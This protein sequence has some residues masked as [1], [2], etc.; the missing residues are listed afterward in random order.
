MNEMI[1]GNTGKRD[2]GINIDME[3]ALY[4]KLQ[5]RTFVPKLKSMLNDRLQ[6]GDKNF[7]FIGEV[8]DKAGNFSVYGYNAKLESDSRG[9]DYGHYIAVPVDT[10]AV[11]FDINS[12]KFLTEEGFVEYVNLKTLNEEKRFKIAPLQIDI[13]TDSKKKIINNL[14][15]TFMKVRKRKNVTFSFEYSTVEEFTSKSVFVLMDLMKYIPYQMRKNISF[16]SHVASNQKLPDM[17]NLAAYPASS[18]FKPHD[19]I[20]LS[21]GVGTTDGIFSAYVEKVFAMSESER[22]SYF[23]KLYD[24]IECPAIKAGVDVRS[25]LYLLDVSTKELWTVGDSKEAIRNIFNSVDD[26]L[27]VYPEYKAIAIKRLKSNANEVIEYILCQIKATTK[28]EELNAVYKSIYALFEVCGFKFDKSVTGLFKE[29]ASGFIESA[30]SS[31]ALIEVLDGIAMID[32]AI[33]DQDIARNIIRQ[34]MSK[35]SEI[36]EIHELYLKLKEKKFIEPHEL[37]ICLTESIEENILNAVEKYSDSK[38]KLSALE[39]MYETFKSSTS[40]REY[41]HVKEVFDRYKSRFS[42]GANAEAVSKGN[43]ILHKIEKDI[44]S[45]SNF[46]DTKNYIKELANI[47]VDTDEGLKRKTSDIYRRVSTKLFDELESAELSYDEFV[48]LLDE[49]TPSVKVLDKNEIYDNPQRSGWGEEKYV[50]DGVYRFTQIFGSLIDELRQADELTEAILCFETSKKRIKDEERFIRSMFNRIGGDILTHWLKKHN[51]AVTERNFKKAEKELN[52]YNQVRVSDITKDV[53]Y[54]YL[55]CKAS[56]HKRNGGFTAVKLII[57]LAAV[58]AIIVAIGFGGFKL[59]KLFFEPDEPVVNDSVETLQ[60]NPK[61]ILSSNDRSFVENYLDKFKHDDLNDATFIIASIEKSSKDDEPK[62]LYSLIIK[63]ALNSNIT[64]DKLDDV[65]YAK[66]DGSN[67]IFD[68]ADVKSEEQ[69]AVVIQTSKNDKKTYIRDIYPLPEDLTK[70]NFDMNP[71][72]YREKFESKK[73]SLEE[74]DL[75]TYA[76]ILKYIGWEKDQHLVGLGEQLSATGNEVTKDEQEPQEGK[77]E[78]SD[79]QET[80]QPST[81]GQPEKQQSKEYTSSRGDKNDT[82]NG[83]ENILKTNNN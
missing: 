55:D 15:E 13:D 65:E 33:L 17:I 24:G 69:Y 60:N 43:E 50:P 27:K 23:E 45:Y 83:E 80:K 28:V 49:I 8:T 71:L 59:Y 54:R 51:K 38:D 20:S 14:M 5:S 19:C 72:D 18:E 42:S 56:K 41:P 47:E 11:S 76:K 82:S 53:F 1:Y 44:R 81:K 22:K 7:V 58:L 40:S 36:N 4:Q 73:E 62:V 9:G 3:Q 64:N 57:A 12:A 37:N 34:H 52:K 48:R 30:P 68:I 75:Q 39:K 25:D 77:G 10:K 79:K 2:E 26:I 46:Y 63:E 70:H 35:K 32:F 78:S 6:E 67:E 31:E 61:Y 29:H 21:G 74:E 66:Y 16:I